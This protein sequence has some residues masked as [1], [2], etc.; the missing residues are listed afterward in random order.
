MS[1]CSYLLCCWKRIFDVTSVLSWQNSLS[2]FPASFCTPRP[3]SPVNTR[4]LLTSYF[5]N[6]V[7]YDEKDIFF[8]AL[9]LEGLIGL[10]R[11]FNFSFFGFSVWGI[12]SD[13]CDVKWFALETNQGTLSF[14]KLHPSTAF[15]T[16]FWTIRAVPFL[17]RDS[18]HKGRY[19]GHLN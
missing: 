7:P 18:C 16:L 14:L 3:N 4:Y 13:Y 10:H 17:L 8:L 2:F 11:A 9:I 5:C 12:D 1:I 6:P 19:N 15:H